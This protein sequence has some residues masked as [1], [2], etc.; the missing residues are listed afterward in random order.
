MKTLISCLAT[1]KKKGSKKSLIFSDCYIIT[2]N[3]ATVLTLSSTSGVDQTYNQLTIVD[4]GAFGNP[5]P[6]N[7]EDV[8]KTLE[9]VD[10]IRQSTDPCAKRLLQER[11]EKIFLAVYPK[12]EH[13]ALS[14]EQYITAKE[15]CPPDIQRAINDNPITQRLHKEL[16]VNSTEILFGLLGFN[17]SRLFPSIILGRIKRTADRQHDRNASQASREIAKKQCTGLLR[18][19]NNIDK[20]VKEEMVAT[21]GI[22]LFYRMKSETRCEIMFLFMF[23]I[24]SLEVTRQFAIALLTAHEFIRIGENTSFSPIGKYG[25]KR[26]QALMSPKEIEYENWN[27]VYILYDEFEETSLVD[28]L[29]F[30]FSTGSV[31]DDFLDMVRSNPGKKFVIPNGAQCS[32]R[33]SHPNSQSSTAIIMKQAIR[34]C[35]IYDPPEIIFSGSRKDLLTKSL[36]NAMHYFGQPI[37]AQKIADYAQDME[38]SI[39]NINNINNTMTSFGYTIRK[40][41]NDRFN[42]LKDMAC[43]P[44]LLELQKGRV[45][46]IYCGWIFDSSRNRAL[47]LTKENVEGGASGKR[48]WKVVEL[49]L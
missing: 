33:L 24:L 17:S 21:S 20:V 43:M 1:D 8:D 46:S 19:F 44:Y 48:I 31:P 7:E 18:L 25:T 42:P 15:H 36:A 35:R 27:G 9:L 3:S 38:S 32:F 13:A 30:Q 6:R 45:V 4:C 34:K 41:R 12:E 37:L 11:C 10:S 29:L 22:P 47:K 5:V 23:E 26:H 28:Q 2:M 49:T 40:V 14:E 16:S 39:I